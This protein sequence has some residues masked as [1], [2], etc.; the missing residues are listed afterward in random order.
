MSESKRLNFN[1]GED[2]TNV[3]E[4]DIKKSLKHTGFNDPHVVKWLEGHERYQENL[5]HENDVDKNNYEYVISNA[6]QSMRNYD[7]GFSITLNP[8]QIRTFIIQIEKNN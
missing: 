7:S 1:T 3:I 5:R 2:F 8:M 6:K 4:R